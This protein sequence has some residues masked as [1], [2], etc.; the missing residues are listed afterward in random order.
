VLSVLLI[1][2]MLALIGA[3]GLFLQEVRLAAQHLLLQDDD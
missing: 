2:A 1:A 3:L